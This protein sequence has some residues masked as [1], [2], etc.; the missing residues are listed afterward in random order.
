MSAPSNHWKLGALRRRRG[1][2][3]WRLVRGGPAA[4]RSLQKATVSI[5]LLLR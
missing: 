1:V 4:P 5:H 3:L 2:V